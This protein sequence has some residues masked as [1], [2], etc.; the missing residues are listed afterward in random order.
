MKDLI[1]D[2]H[3]EIKG[4]MGIFAGMPI[5]LGIG[6]VLLRIGIPLFLVFFAPAMVV[7]ALSLFFERRLP[8][9]KSIVLG[10]SGLAITMIGL[11]GFVVWLFMITS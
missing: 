3:P 10:L 1:E 4:F 7:L 9:R 5:A 2:L 6:M 8:L 11:T